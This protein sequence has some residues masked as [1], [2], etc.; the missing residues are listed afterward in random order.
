MHIRGP[1]VLIQTISTCPQ[2]PQTQNAAHN[3]K[4]QSVRALQGRLLAAT[5]GPSFATS[6]GKHRIFKCWPDWFAWLRQVKKGTNHPNPGY[7]SWSA[8]VHVQ[9]K[10]FRAV[11]LW[12]AVTLTDFWCSGLAHQQCNLWSTPAPW[13]K[14]PAPSTSAGVDAWCKKC[15]TGKSKQQYITCYY[16]LPGPMATSHSKES[17]PWPWESSCPWNG[18]F[19]WMMQLPLSVKV[20][21]V[22]YSAHIWRKLQIT[23]YLDWARILRRL[24]YGRC[25]G[26]VYGPQ[27]IKFYT[28]VDRTMSLQS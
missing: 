19:W 3:N 17:R 21:T 4:V 13:L 9:N 11:T 12:A 24:L 14:T 16:L 26:L 25:V 8:S 23:G 22:Q 7:I 1:P 18:F 28:S 20:K 2:D 6:A 10:T 27:D 15:N 5:S